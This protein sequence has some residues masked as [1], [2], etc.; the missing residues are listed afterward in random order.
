[1]IHL[2]K[3]KGKIFES[4]KPKSYLSRKHSS[5]CNLNQR[6]IL[7][8]SKA[9]E[10]LLFSKLLSRTTSSIIILGTNII[11][12]EITHNRIW[13]CPVS[14]KKL[15]LKIALP[16]KQAKFLETTFKVVIFYYMCKLYIW[17]LLKTILD[18]PRPKGFCFFFFFFLLNL[19]NCLW[20]PFTCNSKKSNN[21]LR[22]S[23]SL[24]FS[25]SI[26]HSSPFFLQVFG[27]TFF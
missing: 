8:L 25:F 24:F 14:T 19:L 20:C 11:W 22:R 16:R 17:N 1:M 4:L 6:I 2:L 13:S 10:Q 27:T 23:F 12:L 26:Y 18:F 21:L 3:V 7:C 9:S 15:F 5:S